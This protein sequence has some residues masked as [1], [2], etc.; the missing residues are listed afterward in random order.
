MAEELAREL[1][2]R[3]LGHKVV[4]TGREPLLAKA[5]LSDIEASKL[6]SQARG[7][8]VEILYDDLSRDHI[9]YAQEADKL[10]GQSVSLLPSSS[11]GILSTFLNR[12]Q[13]IV[14]HESAYMEEIPA[15]LHHI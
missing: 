10:A 9:M 5:S 15:P 11:D 8:I 1:A 6:H 3:H 7:H 12:Y 14:T 2:R 13:A 4:V